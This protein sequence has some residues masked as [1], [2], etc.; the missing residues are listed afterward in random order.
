MIPMAQS[1]TGSVDNHQPAPI[2]KQPPVLSPQLTISAVKT[3]RTPDDAQ[4]PMI[5][6][7]QSSSLSQIEEELQSFE[8]EL[9]SMELT[10]GVAEK[11]KDLL[12]EMI[13]DSGEKG[14]SELDSNHLT[15]T[16]LA[17]Q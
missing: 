15:E 7:Q 5:Q 10:D 11:D 8:K 16:T 6:C 1:V 2:L 4:L 12:D 13:C 14:G 3:E 9:N 17:D